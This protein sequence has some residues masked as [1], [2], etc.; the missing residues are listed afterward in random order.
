MD[1]VVLRQRRA[2]AFADMEAALAIEDAA[3]RDQRFTKAEADVNTLDRD[4][5][6]AESMERLRASTAVGGPEGLPEAGKSFLTKYASLP[7][8][9]HLVPTG[10]VLSE[11]QTL[12]FGDLLAAVVRAERGRGMDDRLIGA[13]LG[14]NE[15]VGSDGGFLVEKDIA[16]GMLQRT[17]QTAMIAN[18]AR[19]VPLSPN[20]NGIRMNALKDNSR[21]TGSR[22]GGIRGYWSEEGGTYTAS[23]PQLRIMRLEL[24]K[25]TG[26]MYATDELLQDAP[27]MASIMSQAFPEEFAFLLDNAVFEG[28]GTGQP[29]GFMKSAAKVTVAKQSGQ[30]ANTIVFENVSDMWSRL[31]PGAAARA[32]WWINQ[33]AMSQLLQM[34]LVIGTGGVPVF[35]P[36]GGLSQSPYGTLFG[37]PVM[38]MEHCETLG[39]EGDIVLCDPSQY[40]MIEKG[41][42]QY[43][44]SIHVAF[45]TGEQAFRFTY[46]V[47]G[48]PIDDQPITPFKGTNTLS[49]FITLATRA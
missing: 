9:S 6:R 7:T 2:A 43:A 21:A 29:L 33:D 42:I 8:T 10:Q 12:A 1:I 26:L 3:E 20:S 15:A 27:A 36:P 32:E 11:A 13:A 41:N 24:K 48:Q 46:R 25:L 5:Q 49:N 39:T 44:T 17:F 22:F 47:D 4:I 18:R 14:S 30:L 16:S 34:S 23:R 37:R 35:L 40:L 19:R 28:S 45:L 38:P 31:V